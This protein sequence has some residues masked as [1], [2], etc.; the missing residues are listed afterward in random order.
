MSGHHLVWAA[1]DGLVIHER[2]LTAGEQHVVFD[3]SGTSRHRGVGLGVDHDVIAWLVR[4]KGYD[5]IQVMRRGEVE[6]TIYSRG[7]DLGYFR[8]TDRYVGVASG[9]GPYK[10]LVYDVRAKE[11][12]KIGRA[13]AAVRADAF[14]HT[15][16]RSLVGA[17]VAVGEGRHE[18]AWVA[19]L[20]AARARD[21]RVTV[22]RAHGLTLEE[23]GYPEDT[24]LAARARQSRAMRTLPSPDLLDLRGAG[25]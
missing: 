23:V 3:S 5:V 1:A 16:V 14:C 12:L 18:P 15:M 4:C 13:V 25:G 22:A 20:L 2:N 7:H 10:R 9:A 19:T 6:A 8:V 21:P 24:Q 17:M 11:L